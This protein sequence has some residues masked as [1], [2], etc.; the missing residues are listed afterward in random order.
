MEG[1][2]NAAPVGMT[3]VAMTS[4]LAGERKTVALKR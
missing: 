1:D 2:G 4:F 3:V